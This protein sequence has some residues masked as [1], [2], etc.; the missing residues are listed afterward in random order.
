[1]G[2]C[3]VAEVEEVSAEVNSLGHKG[4]ALAAGL[5]SAEAAAR[6]TGAA[7]SEPGKMDILL[8]N[9]GGCRLNTRNHVH[10]ISLVDTAECEWHR[11]LDSNLITG[12]R[13]CNAVLPQMIERR[14]RVIIGLAS[15]NVGLVV[16]SVVLSSRCGWGLSDP[17]YRNPHGE[18]EAT[19]WAGLD[20]Q[21]RV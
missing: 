5:D 14:T 9:V 20:R 13:P 7:I 12:F 1:M 15:R 2:S 18:F 10:H 16:R 11:V 6:V 4:L 21:Y 17:W 8:D 19:R 3:N